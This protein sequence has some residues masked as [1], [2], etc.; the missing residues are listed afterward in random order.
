MFH[1]NIMGAIFAAILLIASGTVLGARLTQGQEPDGV[2]PATAPLNNSF[3]YQGQLSSDSNVVDNSCTFT[4]ALFDAAADGNRL[5][6]P[7]TVNNVTVEHGR[8]T[9]RLNDAGQF[10]PDAFN[11][12]PRWL[13]ITV[14][15]AGDSIATPLGRQPL[16]AAP[17]ASYALEAGSASHALEADNAD[18]A[19]SAPW[20][21]ITGIP[22]DIADGDDDTTYGAGAGLHLN[23]NIFSV[24]GAGYDNVIVVAKNGGD[25]TEI[26]AALDSITDASETNRY[27]V[28][29]APGIYEEQVT[30]KEYVDIQGAGEDVTTIRWTGS[31]EHPNNGTASATLVGASNSQLR[32][33]TVHANGSDVSYAVAIHNNGSNPFRISHVTA[34]VTRAKSENWAVYMLNGHTAISDATII[35]SGITQSSGNAYG[36]YN[37]LGSLNMNRN[38][39][40]VSHG[41]TLKGVHVVGDTS[42]KITG[43]TITVSDSGWAYGVH[44]VSSSSSL[45]LNN[46]YI[47][48][49][50]RVVAYGIYQQNTNTVTMHDSHITTSCD[51][52]SYG[53][54]L[55]QGANLIA[56]GSTITARGNQGERVGI[57]STTSSSAQV[58]HSLIHGDSHS[59]NMNN[60]TSVRIG[61]SQLNGPVAAANVACVHSYNASFTPLNSSCQ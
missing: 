12:E 29:V 46:S 6:N 2:P 22:A 35:A 50:G 13:D 43:S 26:Q 57:R 41:Q 33:L 58:R 28:W 16:T 9:V 8:F 44:F 55:Y 47:S 15:C 40:T 1:R 49:S 38:T 11:G 45:D 53:V 20:S 36:V 4:F 31:S 54:F 5:G 60:A 37:N 21:G 48:S 59:I 23:N 32:Y 25:F 51:D 61:A 17:Y 14:Q 3:T 52:G 39:I 42:T 7:Q 27:L 30:M 56:T 19:A 10:G 34:S 18:N 24:K